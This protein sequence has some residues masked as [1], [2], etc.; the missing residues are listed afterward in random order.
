MVLAG[1]HHLLVPLTLWEA[2]ER[3]GGRCGRVLRR[4]PG[5]LSEQSGQLVGLA[6]EHLRY[7]RAVVEPHERVRDNEAALRKRRPFG[8]QG[9]RRLEPSRMVVGEIADHRRVGRLGFGEV[10]EPGAGA[11]EGVPTKAASFDRLQQEAAALP[12]PQAEVC[13]E[14]CDEV[15]RDGG[16]RV[17][18]EPNHAS[19]NQTRGAGVQGLAPTA[20]APLPWRRVSVRDR[21]SR[22]HSVRTPRAAGSP[23]TRRRTWVGT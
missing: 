12:P 23:P 7:A 1:A 18:S 19:R 13:R 15:G 16:Q 3:P 11:D 21:L 2:H 22:A 6:R 20:P 4:S 9:D 5:R 10:D 8:R 17:S 14:R